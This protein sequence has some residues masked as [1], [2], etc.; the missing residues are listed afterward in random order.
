MTSLPSEPGSGALLEPVERAE[1]KRAAF[2]A[3]VLLAVLNVLDVVTTQLVLERGGIELNPIADRMLANNLALPVKLG[4]L[5]L[6]ALQF[7]RH[8]TKIITL[9]VLWLVTGVY[10]FVVLNGTQ[11]MEAMH[12]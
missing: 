2:T 1:L 12:S 9:C 7:A 10:V 5:G 4:I 11:L 8:G 6:L 3:V